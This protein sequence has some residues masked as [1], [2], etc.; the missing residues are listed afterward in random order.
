MRFIIFLLSGISV[1]VGFL[2]LVT[3]KSAIHEIEAFI[4]FLIAAVLLSGAAIM[5][6]LAKHIDKTCEISEMVKK[7]SSLTQASYRQDH[8]ATASELVAMKNNP[9]YC[10]KYGNADSYPDTYNRMFCPNCKDYAK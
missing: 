10:S 2:V 8:P 6:A 5:Q 7:I 3:A 4:L 9:A 1:F